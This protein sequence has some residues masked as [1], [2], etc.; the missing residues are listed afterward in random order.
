MAPMKGN[1]REV[2]EWPLVIRRGSFSCRVNKLQRTVKG[3]PFD[4]YRLT[5]YAPGG[6]R[7]ARDFGSLDGA[8]NAAQEAANA[9]SLGRPDAL[10]FTPQERRDFDAASAILAPL[11]LALYPAAVQLAEA[12]AALPQ[13]VSLIE[14]VRD[15]AKRH[16]SN[17]PKVTVR[18]SV[19]ALL[20]DREAAK[21]SDAY[22]VKL[23]SHLDRFA[24]AFT[25]TPLA[26]LSAPL[27]GEW[28]RSLATGPT[29]LGNRT[30]ANHAGSVV[31]LFRFARSR[32]WIAR[33]LSDEIAEVPVPKPEAIGEVGVFTPRQF[34]AI[35]QAAPD[36]IRATLALGGFAGLRTEEI[37]RLDWSAV[38][39]AERVLIVGSKEAKTASRRVL[40]IDESLAAWLAPL[41]QASGP[42]DPSPTSKALTHRWRRVA[43]KAGVEWRHNALRHSAISYKCAVGGDPSRVAFESGNS[44]RMIHQNYRALVTEAEG[45]AWFAV[46]PSKTEGVALSMKG[47]LH[48]A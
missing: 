34:E 32:G 26:T 2:E 20:S 25:S 48:A 36:D 29:P 19:D 42:V 1:K 17:A 9:F 3:N 10:S 35:L 13:G 41:A 8:R 4:Y 44:V 33:D 6:S 18:E 7:V 31:T 45:R 47:D 46:Q 22:L 14:A 21:A 43:T 28:L 11:N 23:R 40:P 12:L 5:Y 38:K 37:H 24:K 15:Y 16:P 39:L 27:V 30:V